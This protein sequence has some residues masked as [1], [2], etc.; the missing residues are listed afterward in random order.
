MRYVRIEKAKPNMI[1]AKP[2]Y[3]S[4]NRVL[5][6]AGTIMTQDYIQRLS[7]RG[8]DGFYIEDD[9]AKDI[10]VRD[11]ITQELRNEGVDALSRG[12]LDACME[13]AEKIVE[14]IMSHP[15]ISIDMIDLRT[16]DD[17][18]YRHSVNVAVISTIIGLKLGY[19][20]N[21]LVQ[22]STS[23]MLHDV[24]KQMLK[25][26]ILNKQGSLTQ[27][28]YDH[29]KQHPQLA[30]NILRKRMDISS[31]V[32][33]G[34]LSHHENED[35]SG[36][37]IGFAGDEIYIYAKIIHVADVFD[38]LISKRPYKPPYA[39][40]EAVEYLMGACDRLFDRKIVEVFVQCVSIYPLGTEVLLSDGR[41]GIVAANSNP[42][43]PVIRLFDGE[44][45]DLSDS[46]RYRNIT[47]IPET[48]AILV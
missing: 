2:L 21:T 18:T 8:L 42:L 28:E 24:G 44:E 35:G 10:D 6:V 13:V 29:V 22:L 27:E 30:F 3:D 36:Y 31:K 17:Y 40:S 15:P 11:N 43:R 4:V 47:I 37:P 1:L 23:A 45:V 48:D 16:Y 14:Q 5:L 12:D 34:V 38:A 25:T 9:L 26:Q 46:D 19:N 33:A 41:E 7:G 32:R 39:R 20:K